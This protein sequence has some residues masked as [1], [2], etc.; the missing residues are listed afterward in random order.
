MN[1]DNLR[2]ALCFSVLCSLVACS[3]GTNK[4]GSTIK[5]DRISVIEPA[6]TLEADRALEDAR[7]SLSREIVNL[8]WPQPGYDSQ[9]AVP[10]AQASRNPKVLWK[11]D[12]GEG[13]SS[14]FK[15]LAKPVVSR[16]IVYAM[17]AEGRVSSFDAETGK[18]RWER[19]TA[20]KDSDDSAIGGGIAIDGDV[21]YATT[22]FG[23]VVA[24]QAGTGE[25]KWRKALLKP[26][27]AAPTVANNRVYAI[28]I[29]NDLNAL[30]AET[31]D[32]LWHQAGVAESAAL[33]GAASPA[34]QGDLVVVAYNS[35]E[36]FGLRAQNGRVS[37]TYSLA[38][39][40]QI[41]ALPA[42][43]DIRGLPVIERDRIYAISHSGRIAALDRRN[44]DRV[45][46]TDIGGIDT[47]VV[48]RDAVFVY[49]GSNQLIAFEKD[50][51][52]SMWV[53][54]LPGRADPKDKGSEAVVWSGPIL[55]GG[56]LWMVNSEGYL[57]G[58]SPE[59]GSRQV[60]IDLKDPVY[61]APIVANRT[62]YV[63]TDDGTLIA[64]R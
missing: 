50:T 26:L 29:D 28:S 11:A 52:R 34:V 33:M 20:P 19:D 4:I 25:I 9:H 14:D 30:D 44:G 54:P 51:G 7:P 37:W 21:V 42:I 18:K 8:S 6:K 55:A 61:L 23:D 47:P 38:A 39:P 31:G 1:H 24:L 2:R 46:E 56:N 53:S 35:G 36:I 12:I 15:L 48:A 27:R 63:V 10:N 16:G 59:D 17:D 43:A 41:G 40:A 22:G 3:G 5:G 49:G 58:F 62:F 57:T 45:W 32:I 64:L 13:S 60:Q